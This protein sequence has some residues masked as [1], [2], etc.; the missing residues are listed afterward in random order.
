MGSLGGLLVLLC[1]RRFAHLTYLSITSLILTLSAPSVHCATPNARKNED[2]N[3]TRAANAEKSKSGSARRT[4]ANGSARSGDTASNDARTKLSQTDETASP[5]PEAA[6]NSA[7]ASGAETG[8]ED[9]SPLHIEVGPDGIKVFA[10]K[11]DAAQVFVDL[12]MKTGTKVVVDDTVN[13]QITAQITGKTAGEIIDKI[14]G[15]YGLS[16]AQVG[17][18]YLISEGIPKSPSTY[19]LSDIDT[20]TT[21]YVLAPNAKSL[22]PVFLQDH[23]KI[24][25]EQNAVVLSAPKEV[26]RKFR[27]DISQF[28]VPAAQIMLETLMVEFTDTNGKEIESLLGYSSPLYNDDGTVS[29]T[30]PPSTDP[31]NGE[32]NFRSVSTLPKDFMAQLH[33]LVVEGKARVRANPRIATV[34]GQ[35]ADI[36]IGQQKFLSTPVEVRDQETDRTQQINYID[37]GIH[38]NVTPYTGGKGEIIAEVQP[39]ISVFTAVNAAT[40][41]P[42]KSTRRAKT[43][44]RVQDGQSIIIGGLNQMEENTDHRKIPIL[45]DLP[46]IGS[47]FRSTT[48]SRTNTEL[49]IF[50]TPRILTNTG[51]LPDQ[52]EE[53]KMFDRFQIQPAAPAPKSP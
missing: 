46:I 18:A 35:E 16:S 37:A 36:F 9:A 40:G 2:P 45:G 49:Y 43:V 26:L 51:H 25:P 41:L 3:G 27:E 31:T 19:L 23:V 11:A 48:V 38:L 42:D 24:N 47:L 28:D 6:P 4:S 10:V 21:K 15:V 14:T 1:Q 13:R 52:Q 20:I 29:A 8:A 33:H 34:S 50:V 32:I 17:G 53:R 12:G 22:L 7:S 44:L 5:T 39:E 30:I